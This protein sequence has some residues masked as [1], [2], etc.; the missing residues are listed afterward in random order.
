MKGFIAIKKINN[1]SL[2][3]YLDQKRMLSS[4]RRYFCCGEQKAIRCK[5]LVHI[6]TIT[7]VV[8][9][10]TKLHSLKSSTVRIFKHSKNKT[11]TRSHFFCSGE[12]NFTV[13]LGKLIFSALNAVEMSTYYRKIIF[14]HRF[15]FCWLLLKNSLLVQ[16]FSHKKV[17]EKSS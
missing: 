15:I 3:S 9:I 12:N 7:T 6:I 4:D 2:C 16:C 11:K 10:T 5:F 13:V 1:N 14:K 8:I 17:N